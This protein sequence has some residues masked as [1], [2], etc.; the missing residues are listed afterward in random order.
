[1][2]TLQNCWYSW[3]SKYF[4]VCMAYV[5]IAGHI[6]FLTGINSSS[7]KESIWI[8]ERLFETCIWTKQIWK[9]K[10]QHSCIIRFRS[11]LNVLTPLLTLVF[12]AVVQSPPLWT[13]PPVSKHLAPTLI[14]ICLRYKSQN[15]QFRLWQCQVVIL[16][17]R[18]TVHM[19]NRFSWFYSFQSLLSKLQIHLSLIPILKIMGNYLHN[20]IFI[21]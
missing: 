2:L 21:W 12:C 5:N 8:P 16:E 19:P 3:I 9:P 6:P 10:C 7:Y 20:W 15:W 13:S 18:G 14:S 1:M 4:W 11:L 17:V